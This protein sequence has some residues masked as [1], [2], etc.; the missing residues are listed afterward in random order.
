MAQQDSLLRQ[1]IAQIAKPVKGIVGVSLLNIENRD[2][3]SYNGNAR[4]VLHSVMKFPIWR[5]LEGAGPW[6]RDRA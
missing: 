2:T 3:L 4:L 5:K 6:I 1:Q